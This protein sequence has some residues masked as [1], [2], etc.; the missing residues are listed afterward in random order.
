M[1][2]RLLSISDTL[3]STVVMF[4]QTLGIFILRILACDSF[5]IYF[6]NLAEN[7]QEAGPN[8]LDVRTA[9]SQLRG[10][11]RIPLL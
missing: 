9:H 10:R 7:A 2:L 8:G 11:G 5:H 4:G 6:A 3:S 1:S